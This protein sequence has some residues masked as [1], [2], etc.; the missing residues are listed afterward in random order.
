[1]CL[2]LIAYQ[3]HP[4]YPLIIAANRDEFFQRPTCPAEFWEDYPDILAGRDL[5]KG[6]TWLGINK[7]GCMA[8]V[9]N[10][11]EPS[12]EKSGLLSRGSL[13]KDYLQGDLSAK[14]YLNGLTDRRDHYDGFN[15]FAGDKEGLWFIS[16]YMKTPRVLQPGVHGIG[17]GELDT[18]WPKVVLGTKVLSDLLEKDTELEPEALFSLLADRTIPD[19]IQLPDTGVG[20]QLERMLAPIF[21]SGGHYGTRSSTVLLCHVSGQINFTE[22]CFDV[23]GQQ[24][25]TRSFEVVSD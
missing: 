8:A 4:D 5:E 2:I 17:N 15:L 22:R 19:D 24:G 12:A 23:A 1:M 9:T 20:T 21:V 16:S 14:V 13:V 7:S 10:Y 11:R 18:P 3:Q 25:K 6:G